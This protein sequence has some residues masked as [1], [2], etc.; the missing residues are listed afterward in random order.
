[1]PAANAAPLLLNAAAP[2]RSVVER[3]PL[4]TA[5][6]RFDSFTRNDNKKKRSQELLCFGRIC[7]ALL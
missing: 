5:R 2:A 3:Q 4:L 1:M 6:I 7:D